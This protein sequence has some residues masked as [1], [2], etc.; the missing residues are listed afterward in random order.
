MRRVN[1]NTELVRKGYARVYG[2]NDSAHMKALQTNRHYSRLI[3]RLLTCEKVGVKMEKLNKEISRSPK[4]VAWAF[5]NAALG[6]RRL[7]RCRPPLR[8]LFDTPP[9]PK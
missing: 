5:G 1:L 2:P 9:S 7:P 4:L 8:K 6:W 3:T